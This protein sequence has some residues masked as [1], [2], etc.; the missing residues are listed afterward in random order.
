MRT[1]KTSRACANDS[2]FLVDDDPDKINR[3]VPLPNKTPVISTEHLLNDKPVGTL[4]LSAFG[5]EDW[6]EKIRQPLS[7]RRTQLIDPYPI[8]KSV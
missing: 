5:C 4:I 8:L 3:F 1:R 2:D 6:I 7:E